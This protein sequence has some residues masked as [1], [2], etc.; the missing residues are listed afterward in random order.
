MPSAVLQWQP[1]HS[2]LYRAVLARIILQTVNA[3]SSPAAPATTYVAAARARSARSSPCSASPESRT[4]AVPLRLLGPPY[5]RLAPRPRTRSPN[6]AGRTATDKARC[7]LCELMPASMAA[8]PVCSYSIRFAAR[9]PRSLSSSSSAAHVGSPAIP[10]ADR[11]TASCSPSSMRAASAFSPRSAAARAAAISS[12]AVTRTRS[13]STSMDS[14]ASP[15][16][17]SGGLSTAA[18]SP[19]TA[20]KHPLT[21]SAMR[22]LC[23][24]T[25]RSPPMHCADGRLVLD[26]GK[27]AARLLRYGVHR[28]RVVVGAEAEPLSRPTAHRQPSMVAPNRRWHKIGVPASYVPVPPVGQKDHAGDGVPVPAVV[29]HPGGHAEALA[30]V[31]AATRDEGLHGALRRGLPV[32]RHARELDHACRVVRE[33]DDAEAVRRTEVADDEPHSLFH[34]QVQLL[35]AHA[36]AEVDHRHEH[37]EADPGRAPGYGRALAVRPERHHRVVRRPG[38]ILHRLDALLHHRFVVVVR[39]MRRRRPRGRRRRTADD[40]AMRRRRPRGTRRTGDDRAADGREVAPRGLAERA[41]AVAVRDAGGD[42]AVVEDVGALGREDGLAA[43]DVAEADGARVGC[44]LALHRS[45]PRPPPTRLA[46]LHP[47]PR[48]PPRPTALAAE[49]P[50]HQPPPLIDL[51][52]APAVGHCLSR[53]QPRPMLLHCLA[54]AAGQTTTTIGPLPQP[55]S[56]LKLPAI[57]SLLSLRSTRW[58]AVAVRQHT[59]WKR[60]EAIG[61]DG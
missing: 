15:S 59:G 40:P 26:E 14:S 45:L 31:R 9:A 53:I 7:C 21:A 35:A 41:V 44:L 46:V 61:S 4:A 19:A 13:R 12:V 55:T 25:E 3:S 20:S 10:G 30:D 34:Y 29:Q 50:A 39:A 24:A 32:G 23:M 11:R 37:R 56:P 43:A 60:K 2:T 5:R 33:G 1:K 57:G 42:G 22:T 51:L 38:L 58:P 6:C 18:S 54:S 52:L 16:G 36:A 47:I 27:R 28:R 8:R 17:I 48:P 49:P